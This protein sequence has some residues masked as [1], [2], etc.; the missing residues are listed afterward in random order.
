LP[1]YEEAEAQRKEREAAE[2][3]MQE[4]SRL[5][6]PIQNDQ[7]G[8]TANIQTTQLQTQPQN[9]VVDKT[10]KMKMKMKERGSMSEP[11]MVGRFGH[12]GVQACFEPE[13]QAEAGTSH[14]KQSGDGD[15][16]DD[17]EDDV[18]AGPIQMRI[19]TRS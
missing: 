16:G 1:S 3:P 5:R 10:K 9:Q 12:I 18:A 7:E 4:A 11:D 14:S 8:Q 6:L 17:D 19:K 2:I 15:D 13:T